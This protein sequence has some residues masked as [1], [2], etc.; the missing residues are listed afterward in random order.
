[1]RI[2]DLVRGYPLT[3]KLK[4]IMLFA[5]LITF[6]KAKSQACDMKSNEV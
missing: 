5:S 3:P 1:M 4:A 6:L 2:F